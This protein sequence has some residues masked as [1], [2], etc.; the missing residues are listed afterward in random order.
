M[1]GA[2]AAK[3]ACPKRRVL[4]VTGDGGFMMNCQEIET[5]AR[6]PLPVV[7]LVLNDGSYGL[8]KWK[9][10]DRFGYHYCVDFTNPDFAMMGT[11]MGIKGLKLERTE[12][13]IPTLE[14]AFAFQEPCIVECPVDYGENTKLTQH[15]KDVMRQLEP[16]M[17]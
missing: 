7:F 1:P 15:L 2:I 6:L 11:S 12:D 14:Q 13:L 8:I 9:Q 16:K 10:E 4:A 3:L 17:C 5:A